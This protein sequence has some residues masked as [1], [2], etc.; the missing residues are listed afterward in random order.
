MVKR[1]E[2]RAPMTQDEFNALPLLLTRAE[3]LE[4]LG[5]HKEQLRELRESDRNVAVKLP[6]MTQWR[7]RKEVLATLA[8]LKFE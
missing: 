1:R 7:Y 3:A 4:V 2:R 8:R 5:L 6:G